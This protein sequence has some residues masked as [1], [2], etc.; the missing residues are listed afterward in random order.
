MNTMTQQLKEAIENKQI[1][2]FLQPKFSLTERTV[3][4]AEALARWAL[5]EGGFR[6]PAEFIPAL[7]ESGAIVDLDF[8]IYEQTLQTMD[9]WKQAG[10]QPIP[11]SVNFS[12]LHSKQDDF[13]ERVT[14]LANTYHIEPDLIEI[15]MTETAFSG[16]LPKLF[17]QMQQLRDGGFHIA[18]D[19]FGM[20]Y[21]SLSVLDEAPAD[22]VK[23][24]K[25]FL[26]DVPESAKDKDYLKQ[27]C[28]LVRT[29]GKDIIFEGVETEAQAAFLVRNGYE[30][31]QGYLFSPP[32]AA[33][34]FTNR[35]M[36]QA[37]P[38]QATPERNFQL[39]SQQELAE[40][41][42]YSVDVGMAVLAI[43]DRI[44]A[45]YLNSGYYKL[46]GY[47]EAEYESLQ[48]DITQHIHLSD[49]RAMKRDFEY[50]E[51]TKQTF[52]H[53][54]R[55]YHK[56]GQIRWMQTQVN[57]MGYHGTTPVFGAVLLDVTDKKRRE[58]YLIQQSES[59]PMTSLLNKTTTQQE[60]EAFLRNRQGTHAMLLVDVDNFKQ[61]NDKLGHLSGDEVIKNIALCMKNVFRNTDIVGRVG[62]DEFLVF[63][64]YV[65]R[66]VCYRKAM[67]FGAMVGATLEKSADG[68]EVSCSIGIAYYE[69]D[70]EGNDT[71]DGRT[72]HELFTRADMAM[73]RAKE[74]GKNCVVEYDA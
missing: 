40:Q 18:I 73:Y 39:Y 46:F 45:L 44:E 59:D 57:F 36:A 56:N 31:A 69:V 24:D 58:Q 51:R 70:F 8:C 11:V 74:K 33:D 4:G 26:K 55:F 19:D 37:A 14:A 48:R 15:E 6:S 23:I 25:S 54:Y 62:G 72:Y 9:G 60:I 35:Y 50:G 16:D 13:V 63:M 53:D 2:L 22:I 29:A 28:R 20:G 21:S 38:I 43:S 67:E 61:V 7:E 64:K 3:I 17:E 30:K 32:I 65:N 47:T 34:V 49:L 42:L 27:I 68:V 5:E 10:K 66:D 1:V 52:E 71:G 41:L 12:R